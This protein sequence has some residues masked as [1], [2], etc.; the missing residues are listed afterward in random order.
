MSKTMKFKLGRKKLSEIEKELSLEKDKTNDILNVNVSDE[1]LR[2]VYLN[3]AK[4]K[5]RLYD[6]VV[7]IIKD[8]LP[9]LIKVSPK[10]IRELLDNKILRKEDLPEERENNRHKSR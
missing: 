4:Q 2:Q 10:F 1:R 5:I 8:F 6:L 3:E 9:E 7:R